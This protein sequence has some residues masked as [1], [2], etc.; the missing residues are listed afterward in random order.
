MRKLDR[1]RLER[2][3]RDIVESHEILRTCPVT[4]DDHVVRRYANSAKSTKPL[5][6]R[7]NGTRQVRAISDIK[8]RSGQL[9]AKPRQLVIRP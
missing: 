2:A 5:W 6:S 9:V 4:I 8:P 3:I 1:H 7:R